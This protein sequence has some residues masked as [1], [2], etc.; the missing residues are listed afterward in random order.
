MAKEA[1]YDTPTSDTVV[2]YGPTAHGQYISYEGRSGLWMTED[3]QSHSPC[4]HCAAIPRR[5]RC[6]YD[7]SCPIFQAYLK[8]R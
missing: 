3:T 7:G 1:F 8:H 2:M 5:G 4:S 6:S